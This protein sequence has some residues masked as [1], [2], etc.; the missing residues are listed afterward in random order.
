VLIAEQLS[1]L[2][3]LRVVHYTESMAA[4][5]K[6]MPVSEITRR[7]QADGAI[8]GSVDW[9]GSRAHVFVQL[10]RAGSSTPVWVK[11]FDVP[12]RRAAEL[13]RSVARD[14]AA[15]LG[16][17]LS[18][19]DELALSGQDSSAPEAFEA[20]LRA[21][22][23]MRAATVPSVK[24]AIEQLQ[25]A[26]RLDPS[27]GPSLAALARCYIME[28]VGQGK[29]PL[30]EAGPLAREAAERA[31]Q[32]D[33]QLPEA[34]QALAEVKF[35]VDWDW[36]GADNEF[37]RAV[38]YRPN[39][40]DLRSTYAMFL[41][42]RKRLPDAMQ[43]VHQAVALDPMSPM[44]NAALGMLWHYARSDDQAERI[45]RGVLE[46]DPS[47]LPARLGLIR[48]YLQ[49]RRYDAALR[50]LERN[51]SDARGELS[52]GQQSMMALA[53]IGLGRGAEAATIAED[54]VLKEGDLPSVDAAS[55]F[56][57]LNQRD[58]A[59]EIIARAVD[60]KS[61]KVLFLRLDPRFDALLNEPRYRGLLTRMGFPS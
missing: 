57:A 38:E 24:Q 42:S 34:H 35:Y 48:T 16:L 17:A 1:T 8:S 40:G 31:L 49:T 47:F 50:E 20:Y 59:L 9:S 60:L 10:M 44:A 21:R 58:R 28:S 19:A 55:V 30:A 51:R 22:V 23:L 41:A 32:L 4:R 29:R 2:P 39:S 53:Y 61:P 37:K 5:D 46:A 25:E 15:A 13:P 7:A 12:A 54:L 3:S 33:S 45:Y 27:H 26:L 18:A 36:T 14:V 43:E 56:L 6:G 52:T 11:Q